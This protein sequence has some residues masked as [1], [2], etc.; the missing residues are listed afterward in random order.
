MDNT[1]DLLRIKIEKAKRELSEE[2]LNAIASVDWKI[3]ILEMRL[4]KGYTFEQLG[5]LETETELLLCGLV[6]AENYPKELEKRLKISRTS[7]NELVNE[8]NNLVFKKIREELVKNIEKKKAFIESGQ[9]EIKNV[10]KAESQ[11]LEKAGIKIIPTTPV[12][13]PG[14]L[15]LEA[16]TKIVENREDIL[17]KIEKPEAVHPILVQKLSSSMQVPMAKTEHSLNNLT[18]SNTPKP[19]PKIDPYREIP[20]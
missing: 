17:K 6:S 20:E 16:G 8:M 12:G 14:E 18:P 7:A 19:A 15:E 5:D 10:P 9:S 11:I 13:R 4:K 3:P 1:A 2:T